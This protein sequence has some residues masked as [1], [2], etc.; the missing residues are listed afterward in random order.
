MKRLAVLVL[1]AMLVVF[2]FDLG[3]Q[4]YIHE[5]DYEDDI[6]PAP[7]RRIFDNSGNW[8]Q[9]MLRKQLSFGLGVWRAYWSRVTYDTGFAQDYLFDPTYLFS[10]GAKYFFYDS[11]FG[12]GVDGVLMKT[13]TVEFDGIDPPELQAGKTTVT[14]W[15]I[16]INAYGRYPIIKNLNLI[17]GAGITCSYMDMGGY[18]GTKDNFSAA[19][20]NAKLGAEFFVDDMISVS[21]FATY[22]SFSQGAVI[23]GLENQNANV[24]LTSFA[25][26]A[27]LYL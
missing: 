25:L 5:D 9:E 26:M 10:F 27:N 16:D 3:A 14:Q 20:W 11:Y 21:L 22:H 18:P 23:A 7:A 24:K 19:G 2:A 13:H 1:T 4:A 8:R 12:V 17:G 15:L 6:G